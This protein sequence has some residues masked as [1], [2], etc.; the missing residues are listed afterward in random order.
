MGVRED[1]LEEVAL[2]VAPKGLKG[3]LVGESESV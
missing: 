2:E 3:Q 1:I